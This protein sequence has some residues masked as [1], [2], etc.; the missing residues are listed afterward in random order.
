M[1]IENVEIKPEDEGVTAVKCKPGRSTSFR[2][3]VSNEN[4]K[5]IDIG[6]RLLFKNNQQG[7]EKWITLQKEER[8]Q[9]LERDL[10]GERG[11]QNPKRRKTI[12]IN[13]SPPS[14][15]L[16]DGDG[17]EECQFCLGIHERTNPSYEIES[18]YITV[19]VAG[20]PA[21]KSWIKR[22]LRIK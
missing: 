12:T 21:K 20:A 17:P 8:E 4:E 13:I 3:V 10:E 14:D 18:N 16:N 5:K 19:T 11:T 9:L 7:V 6:L 1:R 15:L 22:V 2:V